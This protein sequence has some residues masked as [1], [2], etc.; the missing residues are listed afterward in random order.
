M[1]ELAY[2]STALGNI[3]FSAVTVNSWLTRFHS[4]SEV[5]SIEILISDNEITSKTTAKCSK[6]VAHYLYTN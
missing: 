3:K 6:E 2:K 4:R 1:L 5:E